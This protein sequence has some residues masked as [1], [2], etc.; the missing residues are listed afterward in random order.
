MMC[1]EYQPSRRRIAPFSPFGAFSYSATIASLYSGL[2]TRRDGFGAGSV[3]PPDADCLPDEVDTYTGI[4]DP[5]PQVSTPVTLGVSH[6]LDQQGSALHLRTDLLCC[7]RARQQRQ[8]VKPPPAWSL[9]SYSCGPV[10]PYSVVDGTPSEQRP[11]MPNVQLGVATVIRQPEVPLPLPLWA[12]WSPS[13]DADMGEPVSTFGQELRR[14]RLERGLSLSQV[15]ALVHY[16]KGHLSKIENGGRRP[17]RDLARRLDQVLCARG[18]LAGLLSEGP[19]GLPADGPEEWV[20]QLPPIASGHPDAVDLPLRFGGAAFDAYGALL[21]DLRVLGQRTRP[22]EVLAVGAPFVETLCKIAQVSDADDRVRALRLA[23]RYAE[24]LGWMAQENT[25]DNGA[26]WWIR[27]A[28][29]LAGRAGDDT[30]SGYAHIRMAELAIYRDDAVGVLRYAGYALDQASDNR[31][32]AAAYQRI[33]QGH[34]IRNEESDCRR[35]LDQ[36]VAAGDHRDEQDAPAGMPPLG[37]TTMPNPAAF[38]RGWCMLDLARAAEAIEALQPQFAQITE[39]AVRVRAR[40]GARLALAFA[41]AGELDH[42]CEVAEPTMAATQ[43]ADSA[44]A[45][46]DLRS[47]A[48]HLRRWGNDPHVRRIQ[49]RLGA[50]LHREPLPRQSD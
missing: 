13:I 40:C 17:G 47:L 11:A 49:P 37:G 22:A 20:P 43:E 38:V 45:R 27:R 21:R 10:D 14:R 1:D 32:R 7:Q 9:P 48:R 12:C 8:L 26:V 5:R 34:A 3:P 46:S 4:S 42:A 44:T 19:P 36:S 28:M 30:M 15:S 35:A 6:H 2:K 39:K 25:D 50:V 29:A 31:T 33:A 24:Y 41:C 18:D 23:S 16:T